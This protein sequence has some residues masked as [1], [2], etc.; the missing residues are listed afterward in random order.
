MRNDQNVGDSDSL[1]LGNS[2]FCTSTFG[3]LQALAVLYGFMNLH[4]NA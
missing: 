3:D 2:T 1:T 4:G